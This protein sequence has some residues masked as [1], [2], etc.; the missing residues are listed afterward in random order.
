MS[1]EVDKHG[2]DSHFYSGLSSAN[3][4]NSINRLVCNFEDNCLSSEGW[5]FAFFV[6]EVS[7]NVKEQ[8]NGDR[9]MCGVQ[10]FYPIYGL[11]TP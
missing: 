3:G 6:S 11:K 9:L 10:I 2:I 1:E 8:K 4:L 7:D 5:L